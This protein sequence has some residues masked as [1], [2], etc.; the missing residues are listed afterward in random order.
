VALRDRV[1]QAQAA[2]LALNERKRGKPRPRDLPSLRLLVD[3]IVAR[4][5]VP[6]LL[7]VTAHEQIHERPRRPDHDRDVSV[8]VAVDEAALAQAERRLGWR[9]YAT[10]APPTLG[11]DQAVLAYREAHLIEGG[12][13]RLKGQPLSLTPLFLQRDDHILG[14]IRLL[15]IGVRLLTLVQYV[16]RQH[17]AA[18]GAT[19]AGLAPG[20]PTRSTARPTTEALLAAFTSLTLT[21]IATP[22]RRLLHLTTLSPLHQQILACLHC[23]AHLYSRFSGPLPQP[24]LKMSER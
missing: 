21:I 20:N 8:T 16:V 24:R 2:I 13:R 9:V 1:A 17:L 10:N 15:S 3:A 19:L 18:Y 12:F 7:Q 14:L 5:A 23:P 22:D 4:Y 6:D 11:L